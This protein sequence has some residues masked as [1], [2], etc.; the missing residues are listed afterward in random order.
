MSVARW[1]GPMPAT[2]MSMRSGSAASARS[3]RSSSSARVSCG[4]AAD[5]SGAPSMSTT[6]VSAGRSAPA[7]LAAWVG[8]SATSTREPESATM[9]VA[10]SG[11]VV[12]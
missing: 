1:S 8:F 6:W 3:P 7:I 5:G 9:K 10:S 2:I 4:T 12:G 11:S